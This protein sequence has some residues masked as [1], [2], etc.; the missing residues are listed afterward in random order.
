MV[1]EILLCSNSG[2]R[3]VCFHVDRH[4]TRL[5]FPKTFITAP[6]YT[7]IGKGANPSYQIKPGGIS[8]YLC[9]VCSVYVCVF[10]F[11]AY[12][13]ALFIKFDMLSTTHPLVLHTN[14]T[15]TTG[16]G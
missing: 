14:R 12:I 9:L 4:S 2:V 8:A 13:L 1:C 16:P 15:K 10:F 7:K 5:P 3:A 11:G 6:H